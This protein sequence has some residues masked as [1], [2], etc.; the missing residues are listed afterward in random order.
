MLTYA[1]V[2]R[3][4][5]RILDLHLDDLYHQIQE[6]EQMSGPAPGTKS[7]SFTSTKVQILAPDELLQLS[8]GPVLASTKVQILAQLVVQKYKY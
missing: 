5:L 6:D 1:D 8:S 3:L 7:T 4:D 2:C